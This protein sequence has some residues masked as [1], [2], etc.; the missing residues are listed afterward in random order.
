MRARI[1]N[2]YKI[3]IG[4]KEFK[5]FREF[6]TYVYLLQNPHIFRYAPW[7]KLLS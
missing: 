1:K 7:A 6:K 5:E 2:Y 3:I 4:D